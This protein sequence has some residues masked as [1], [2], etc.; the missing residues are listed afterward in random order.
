MTTNRTNLTSA[1]GRWR[2]W[3]GALALAL[4]ALAATQLTGQ[5]SRYQLDIVTTLLEYVALA[6][7][8]NILAGYS[9]QVSLG[10]SAFVGT[11]AYAATLLEIHAGIGF[12]IGL[13][14][15]LAAGG[16][17]ALLLALPLLR[18]RGDYFSIG[19]LVAALAL[20]AWALNWDFAGGS[21][22]LTLPLDALPDPVQLFQLACLVAGLS[23]TVA[24]T[25]AY[26]RFGLRLKAVRDNEA[27]AT[28]LGVSATRH[29]LAALVI[30]GALSG[31]AGGLIAMQQVS[32][33]PTGLLGMN[34]TIN[35]LVMT[36]VGGIGTVIGPLIGAIAVYYLLTKQ[37]ESYQTISVIMEGALLLVIVRF[38]P[39]GLW[40]LLLGAV[41]WMAHRMKSTGQPSRAAT[42]H[43]ALSN[44]SS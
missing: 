25:V 13:L 17:L 36:T 40:P 30:S 37:L 32:F 19:T 35:A 31:L 28:G 14:A 21:T 34:W 23:M 10:V 33:E 12:V 16:A 38:A 6:Q 41:A 9:G 26:S 20:Q 5:L 4:L 1:D 8:W 2:V 27:A 15:A 22:G 3:P 39:R 24:F 42:E 7:A 43:D 29:R 44:S 18:L 11:G